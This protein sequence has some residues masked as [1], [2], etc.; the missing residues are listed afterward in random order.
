VSP[1]RKNV[2]SLSE[3]LRKDAARAARLDAYKR[4][5]RESQSLAERA[6]RPRPAN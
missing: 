1:T 3:K 6:P 2:E 5:I 4:V